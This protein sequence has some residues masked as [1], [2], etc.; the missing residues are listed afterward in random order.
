MKAGCR[1]FHGR[2]SISASY[3]SRNGFP[4]EAVSASEALHRWRDRKS[5]AIREI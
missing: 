2:I 4:I 1:W 3:G 5:G